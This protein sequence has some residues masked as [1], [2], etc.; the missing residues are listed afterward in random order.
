MF[1]NLQRR[2][3]VAR[4]LTRIDWITKKLKSPAW[5]GVGVFV[6]S[7]GIAAP[8]VIGYL[9]NRWTT[10]PLQSRLII[11]QTITKDLIDFPTSVSSRTQLLVDGKQQ[12]EL[13]LF[14]VLVQ[15][16]GDRPMLAGDVVE[17]LTG[18]IDPS[19]KLLVVQK[20][21]E[22]ERPR[23][24]DPETNHFEK[25]KTTPIKFEVQILDDRHFEVTPKLM[26][27]DEWFGIEIYTATNETPS[28]NVSGTHQTVDL[29]S[30]LTFECHIA[31][32]QCPANDFSALEAFERPWFLQV[33]VIH[34][35]WTV[36]GLL[37]FMILNL[38]LLSSLARR[39]GLGHLGTPTRI[40]LL[41]IATVLSFFTAEIVVYWGMR[42][43]PLMLAI[44]PPWWMYSI[45]ALNVI[46]IILLCTLLRPRAVP[47]SSQTRSDTRK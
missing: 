7:I 46:V 28:T 45:V 37:F 38:V 34:A 27:P 42:P 2:S 18:V 39:S 40:S 16:K 47:P 4:R 14:V 9:I 31:G 36:Y 23:Y 1:G 20:A 13:R 35:G 29:W 25:V 15:Y 32:V 21:S 26:N 19:R 33:Y 17:P 8:F 3:S 22:D 5:Q 10:K 12:K 24:F 41:A 6:T 44:E 43:G 11:D 30:E